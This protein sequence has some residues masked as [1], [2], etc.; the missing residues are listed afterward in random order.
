MTFDAVVEVRPT[1]SIAG[2]GGSQVTLPSI[3]VDRRGGRRPDRPAARP[4]RRALV[5]GPRR[6]RRRPRHDRPPRHAPTGRGPARRGLPLR[7]RQRRRIVGLDDQL[8]GPRPATSCSSRLRC[9]PT[10][11]RTRPS[12]RCS[13]RTSRRRS[14]PSS[15]DEWASEASEFDTLEALQDDLRGRLRQLKVVQAQL[16]LRERTVDALVELVA[17]DPPE[18]LVD[19]EVRERLHDL[20]HRLEARRLTVEQFL[21]ASGRDEEELSGRDPGR[22]RPGRAPRPGP[23]GPGRRRGHRGHRRRARR[24]RGGD[25][26]AGGHQCRPTCGADSTAQA[27]CPR[28]APTGGRRRH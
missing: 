24:G 26:A 11:P 17:E 2:Y 25:G 14:F 18:A 19:E 5:G 20:G 8:R 6:T 12:S 9:R 4:V 16:A 23:P 1:V 3:E 10:T 27:G 7:G 22:R 13:S 28:Y 21:Q 15:S